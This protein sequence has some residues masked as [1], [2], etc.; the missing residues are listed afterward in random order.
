MMFLFKH[1]SHSYGQGLAAKA[2]ALKGG[3]S[4]TFAPETGSTRVVK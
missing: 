4:T 1:S 3:R 2:A